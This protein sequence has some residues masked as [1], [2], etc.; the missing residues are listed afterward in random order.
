MTAFGVSGAG[1]PLPGGGG[2]CWL[3][4]QVVFKPGQHPRVASWSAEVLAGLDGP[5]FRVPGPVR[6]GD[7]SWVVDGWAAWS[8]VEGEPDPVGRWAELVAACRAF[9]AALGG[10][11]APPWLGR[12]R[13]Q[14]AVADRVAWGETEVEVAPELADLVGAL[15]AAARPVRSPGQLMHGDIAGNVVFAAGQPPAVIDFSPFW[16]PAGYALAI[17]AVDVLMWSGA[18]LTWTCCARRLKPRGQ[19]ETA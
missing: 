6:A 10:T 3:V 8:W 17:A 9:H 16:R 14:W 15:M 1:R 5:G 13:S 12:G 2:A 7:G 11:G 18:T 19:R 4:G